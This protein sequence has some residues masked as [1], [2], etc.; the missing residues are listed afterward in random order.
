MQTLGSFC[1]SS[2]VKS[3]ARLNKEGRFGDT[4]DSLLQSI[5]RSELDV[6]SLREAPSSL[7][8]FLL[9]LSGT[10]LFFSQT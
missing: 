9:K 10:T 3:K 7:S 5:E 8:G 4:E 6:C 2:R 1:S